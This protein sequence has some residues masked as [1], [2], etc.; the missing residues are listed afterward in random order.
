[1]INQN[2][3]LTAVRLERSQPRDKSMKILVG[4]ISILFVAAHAHAG[5]N[6]ALEKPFQ[7]QES[8]PVAAPHPSVY[9]LPLDASSLDTDP[10]IVDPS[11]SSEEQ[12]RQMSDIVQWLK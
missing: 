9:V 6:L 11:P 1:M 8:E 10:T 5:T 4:F 7:V 3:T 2:Q 12:A